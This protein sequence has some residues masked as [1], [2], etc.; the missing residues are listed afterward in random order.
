MLLR[1]VSGFSLARFFVL[2]EARNF[3]IRY[4]VFVISQISPGSIE[5]R[6]ATV[7]KNFFHH[8]STL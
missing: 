8:V 1:R 7:E 5:L 2:A 6:L 3:V 4:L